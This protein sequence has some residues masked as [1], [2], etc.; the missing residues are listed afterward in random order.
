MSTGTAPFAGMEYFGALA[1]NFSGGGRKSRGGGTGVIG[2]SRATIENPSVSLQDPDA[3][4][5]LFGSG[6]KSDAGIKVTPEKALTL[7][8][9]W[10]AVS[11]ISGDIAR[12]PLDVYRRQDD[13][14]REVDKAHPAWWLVRKRTNDEMHAFRFWRT[15]MVHALIWNNGW[16][17]IDR[18]GRGEPAGLYPLMPDRTDLVRDRGRLYCVTETHRPNG[19]PY[20]KPIPYDDVL[21]VAGLSIQDGLGAKLVKYARHALGLALSRQGFA[22]KFFR[23]GVR[24][25]GILEVPAGASPNFV[26]N[27]EEGFLKHHEG[28]DGWFKTVI[29]RDGV[30][31]HETSFNAQEAQMNE[32]NEEAVREVAR[33]FNL[34]PSRLGV[35]GS[36]SYNSKSEDNQDYLDTTLSPWLTEIA[37]ECAAKLLSQTQE[38]SDS[39]YFEHNTRALLRMD[40]LKRVQAGSMGTKARL[41]TVDEWRHGENMSALPNGEGSKVPP[42]PDPSKFAGGAEK[43]P[44]DKARGPANDGAGDDSERSLA[45]RRVVFRMTDHARQK[46]ASHRT[47]GE[48]LSGNLVQH[49]EAARSII[50]DDSVVEEFVGMLRSAEEAPVS[51]LS[52]R[53]EQLAT[54]FERRF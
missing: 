46:G 9:F 47:F 12:L 15:L 49:R 28:E 2:E 34:P 19:E 52:D 8:A 39:H 41:F 16:A 10:Q 1:S 6:S 48:W 50:G 25:G 5:K 35:K 14:G 40:F 18:N 7:A 32:T 44:N 17:Y 45:V 27:V 33:Y 11:M 54:T 53:V 3:W 38:L 30:K 13:D 42:L 51:E 20:L 4:E 22:S 26:K 23:H 29:L 24:T 43:G 31:F 21:H 37:S 36:V